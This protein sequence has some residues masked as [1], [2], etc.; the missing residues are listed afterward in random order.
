MLREEA[1]ACSGAC[2]KTLIDSDHAALSFVKF[3]PNSRFVLTAVLDGRL[4]LWDY[5][6][7][8]TVKIYSGERP[9]WGLA[10]A[11]PRVR[12]PLDEDLALV[13]RSQR[14][15]LGP[16]C[17]PCSV[18]RRLPVTPQQCCTES[19]LQL[20]LSALGLSDT[21]MELP[22][23]ILNV[24]SGE[25]SCSAQYGWCAMVT[26]CVSTSLLLL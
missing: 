7:S 3:S 9:A 1:L 15:A 17:H 4:K 19:S 16:C 11:V 25:T 23:H 5:E 12:T 20:L 6:H 10:G 13:L 21:L 22:S 8:R 14:L 18:V 2:L 26:L 24:P